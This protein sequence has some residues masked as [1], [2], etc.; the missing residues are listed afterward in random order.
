MP[1]LV[2]CSHD[3][4]LPNAHLYL[5]AEAKLCTAW[6]QRR[7]TTLDRNS[8]SSM[9]GWNWSPWRHVWRNQ[10]SPS[11]PTT[12][13]APV[14]RPLECRLSGGPLH[15]GPP[16]EETALS[17]RRPPC[18]IELFSVYSTRHASYVSLTIS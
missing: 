11:L 8:L 3:A 1:G 13:V 6:D 18:K 7:E 10:K 14:S 16:R 12:L 5:H 2:F 9:Q 4:R 17:H 15:S